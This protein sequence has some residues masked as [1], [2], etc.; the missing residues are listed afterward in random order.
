MLGWPT[1]SAVQQGPQSAVAW[2]GGQAA[3]THTIDLGIVLPCYKA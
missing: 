3:A 1:D 2:G